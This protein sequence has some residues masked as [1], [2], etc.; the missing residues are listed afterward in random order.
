M[1]KR[2]ECSVVLLLL[3]K[4]AVGS[5]GK[6]VHL[7]AVCIPLLPTNSRIILPEDPFCCST[8]RHSLMKAGRPSHKD[9]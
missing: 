1:V 3:L 7:C 8:H 2:E 9:L 6:P 4:K 5:D